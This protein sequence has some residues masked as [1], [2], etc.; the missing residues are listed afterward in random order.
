[1]KKIGFQEATLIIFYAGLILLPL[2]F[3]PW[4]EIPFEIPRVFFFNR[5]VE[6]LALFAVFTLPQTKRQN[7]FPK[8]ILLLFGFLLVAFI[9]SLNGVDF[10]KSFWGNPF[11]G[12]GLWT[13]LHLI[14]LPIIILMISDSS[15]LTQSIK[16]VSIGVFITS[17]LS[18]MLGFL[19]LIT[20]HTILNWSGAI[21][22]SFGNPNFLAGYLTV[23][24]PLTGYLVFNQDN[25]GKIFWKTTLFLQSL[26]IIFTVAISGIIGLVLFI[27][28]AYA[29]SN[30]GKIKRILLLLSVLC[31][32]VII[33]F[34]L[35]QIKQEVTTSFVPGSRIRI[36]KK[37]L[38]AT[39]EKPLFGWGW[40]NFDYAFDTAVYPIKF[41]EDVYVDKAHTYF[42]EVLTT[43]GAIGLMAYLIIIVS[44][45]KYLL[46]SK[47]KV[48]QY[49]LLSFLLFVFHSQTNVISIS[50]EIIFW[51]IVGLAIT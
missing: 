21:G 12:D 46:K 11:R 3:W 30:P 50:E 26:A 39:K 43:T 23:T 44:V 18:V 31:L 42:L 25:S 1:M 47:K 29:I 22:L 41:M 33:P 48:Y 28:G 37:A 19:Y 5:W 4:A 17:L 40:A 6:I 7:K 32:V 51:L 35:S 49:L 24:L 20:P 27:I 16:A 9:S 45:I 2:I 10:A 15:I 34:G 8:M 13:L 14:S 38:L 36:I